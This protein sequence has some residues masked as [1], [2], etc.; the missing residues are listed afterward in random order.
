MWQ[1]IHMSKA[2]LAYVRHKAW[3]LRPVWYYYITCRAIPRDDLFGGVDYL[4][5]GG[6]EQEEVIAM[7]EN[8]R[9]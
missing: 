4:F 1:E 7:L 8:Y 6:I 2:E 5:M 9:R 3:H